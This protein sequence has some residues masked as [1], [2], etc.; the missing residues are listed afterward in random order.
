MKKVLRYVFVAT[1]VVATGYSAYTSQKSNNISDL[2]LAN[3]EALADDSESGGSPCGGPKQNGECQ[4]TNTENCKD[5]TG[6]Q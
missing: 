2:L 4:S 1:F 3:M 6:C 5:L